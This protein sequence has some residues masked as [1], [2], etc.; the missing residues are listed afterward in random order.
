MD[1]IRRE[2]QIP[3][4][5]NKSRPPADI[6]GLVWSPPD[7]PEFG[8]IPVSVQSTFGGLRIFPGGDCNTYMAS[9]LCI[10]TPDLSN[11]V[12]EEQNIVVIIDHVTA[13]SMSARD[14]VEVEYFGGFICWPMRILE[15]DHARYLPRKSDDLRAAILVVLHLRFL[16]WLDSFYFS[17]IRPGKNE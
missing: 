3:K 12:L 4:H 17:N 2:V 8:I 1:A 13:L 11:L 16:S 14:L 5:L 10:A 9:G 6:P 15:S 7:L